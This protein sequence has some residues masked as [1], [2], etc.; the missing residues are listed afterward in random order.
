LSFSQS[1]IGQIDKYDISY[2]YVGEP[3]ATAFDKNGYLWIVNGTDDYTTFYKFDGKGLVSNREYDLEKGNYRRTFIMVSD[4]I[5]LTRYNT[6][7]LY[8]P[9]T[10]D[11]DSIWTLPN[12]DNF[13]LSYKD[14]L[15]HIWIFTENETNNTHPVYISE[16]GINF[17][18]AFDALKVI[19]KKVLR[20]TPIQ[21]KA[22]L[23][24]ITGLL[25][26]MTIVDK[27][28]QVYDIDGNPAASSVDE[29]CYTYRLDNNNN[30]WRI[31]K[32]QISVYNPKTRQFELHPISNK[33]NI[34][35]KCNGRLINSGF[36]LIDVIVDKKEDIW[37]SGED[38]HICKYEKDRDEI[39]HFR[40]E[41]TKSVG[42]RGGYI[43]NTYLDDLGNVYGIGWGGVF[44]INED[45]D[46]FQS[47]ASDMTDKNH[48]L[49]DYQDE[50]IRRTIDRYGELGISNSI[51]GFHPA[52]VGDI[53][54]YVD[55]RFIF[56]TNISNSITEIVSSNT[57]GTNIRTHYIRGQIIIS[58]WD[59][60]YSLDGDTKQMTKF[61]QYFKRLERIVELPNGD[62]W[63]SG[64]SIDEET[65]FLAKSDFDKLYFPNL[66]NPPYK[67][68]MASQPVIRS[69]TYDKLSN[70]WLSSSKGLYFIKSGE[71]KAEK[72]F[73]EFD[74]TSYNLLQNNIKNIQYLGDN[75]LGFMQATGFG[76]IDL[77]SNSVEKFISTEEL[78]HSNKL[79]ACLFTDQSIWYGTGK[80]LVY[81]NFDTAQSYEFSE[82]EGLNAEEYISAITKVQDNQ[83]ALSTYNGLYLYNP[84]SLLY[85]YK[86]KAKQA[87]DT[88]LRLETFTYI[89]G[90]ND[91]LAEKKYLLD[92]D[93]DPITLNYDDK[94]YQFKFSIKHHEF[95]DRHK[96]SYFLEGYSN[97]W[98]PP[99]NDN[100]IEF[101]SLP[102]GKYKLK[103]R[104]DTG[105]GVWSNQEI[106]IP[107]RVKVA[108][109]KSWWFYTLI[110][111]SISGI[112]AYFYKNKY[113]IQQAKSLRD[114]E[115][116]EL[117]RMKEM[118]QF[119]N[120]FYTNIT[121]EF[122]TPLTVIMG[123]T[124]NIEEH[125]EEKKLINRNTKNL[126]MLINQMLDISK[127]EA[128]FINLNK[129]SDDIVKYVQYLSE[130]FYS[131]AVDYQIRFSFYTEVESLVMNYDELKVQQ[132]IYNLISN[133]IKFTEEGGKVM[134]HMKTS[135][136]DGIPHVQVQVIDT[137]IGIPA[138]DVPHIFDRFYQFKDSI[139]KF[140]R[141]TGIGLSL[142]KLLIDLMGGR[143]DV[144]SVEN[145]G[146][147]FTVSFPIEES[148]SEVQA[149]KTLRKEIATINQALQ[150]EITTDKEE[151]TEE[152]RPVLLLVEDN[153][154]VATYIIELLKKDYQV[155]MVSNG[156]AGIDK[157]YEIVPDIII[158]DIMMPLKN[159]YELCQTLKN[160]ERTSHIPIIL[161]TAKVAQSDKVEGLQHG[162]DAF[163]NKPFHKE[164][165]FIRL[166]QLVLTRR[167]IQRY[168]SQTE[169][170]QSANLETAVLNHDDSFLNRLNAVVIENMS[171][172]EFGVNE[173]TLNNNMNAIQIYRKLKALTGKTPSLFI[174]SIRLEKSKELLSSTDMTVSEVAYAVGFKDPSYF[175]R[176]FLKEYKKSP[177]DYRR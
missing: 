84:D 101:S 90:E 5:L 176:V 111:L 119:K 78:G 156:A 76:I 143:I 27:N 7:Y 115:A 74:S 64:Y 162:A 96:F 42:G 25:D 23:L 65:P 135:E 4:K 3:D 35:Q 113:E 40:N 117:I 127:A 29:G 109:F 151:T 13:K 83:I 100:I 147:T 122:R 28:G 136:I 81:Y 89:L 132:I 53:I 36:N 99:T 149:T 19:E 126:L 18:Y 60:H 154:D 164:E 17:N 106:Q 54:Y 95:T 71:D 138:S 66:G 133:A 2:P 68:T 57:S 168:Y 175:S 14:E 163:L 61:D 177:R 144:K 121:H 8:D 116:K 120:N 73:I 59:A 97:R 159:G 52:V 104:G 58:K 142:C 170:Y 31:D 86:I 129:T 70:L 124:N 93:I 20:N 172:P 160:D 114:Q 110:L 173:L 69:M 166:K 123:M 79:S 102:P 130:S 26:G 41:I 118:D 67:E 148:I 112:I 171:N 37:M 11:L 24:Y 157:A 72:L 1:A 150:N 34:K 158:S 146:T 46:Y 108:W 47:F 50:S 75:K 105:Y 15:D 33:I 30:L 161:L 98:S 87:E 128:G 48:P 45:E 139:T 43:R 145:V 125:D 141:G 44:K 12:G 56:K 16:D 131:L 77:N 9:S 62:V 103:V 91:S 140:G 92:Q 169:N 38:M 167:R 152:D 85:Q 82:D 32:R 153:R 6:L 107:F 63:A 22:G 174:R 165:L 51:I 88:P 137:G 10:S 94:L 155:H 55:G 39:V 134:L 21:D 49:Y 80:K